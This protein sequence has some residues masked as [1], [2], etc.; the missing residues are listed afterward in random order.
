M[1]LR[2]YSTISS[3]P[4]LEKETRIDDILVNLEK[5][6]G[7]SI[8][9]DSYFVPMSEAVK[10]VTGQVLTP[11]QVK[12]M[13]DFADGKDTGAK[14]PVDRTHRFTGDIAEMSQELHATQK[15]AEQELINAKEQFDAEQRI[16]ALNS[17]ASS[18]E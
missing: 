1:I 5:D 6:Y 11:E 12:S 4:L 9:D 7:E 13:Y 15:Q 10:N 16:D 2:R 3:V 17:S 8:V 14:I 18:S